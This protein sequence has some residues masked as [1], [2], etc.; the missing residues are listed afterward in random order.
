[1]T[2]TAKLMAR[3]LGIPVILLSQLA[4]ECEKR[5]NK[6]PMCSDLRE[7]G[8]IEQDADIILFVYRDEVY[9]EHSE[10]KGIAEIIIGKGRDIA[11]GTVRAAFFGQYSRFEQLAA[12]WV[13]PS[14][15]AKVTS[16]ADRYT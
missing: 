6:R 1:M 9:H 10:A 13:G 14:K 3:E 15:P 7:S 8:A 4:R 2:R 16:M 5:P 12:G 11:G